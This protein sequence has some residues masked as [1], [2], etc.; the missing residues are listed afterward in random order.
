MFDADMPFGKTFRGLYPATA[1][2][3]SEP[4]LK[5]SAASKTNPLQFLCLTE[6]SGLG[7]G[8]LWETV[9]ALPG[10]SWTLN[11]GESP[12]D[13]EESRLW[14]ILQDEPPLKY[15]LSAKA[16]QGILNR[17]AKRG[18]ELPEMLKTA[19]T[20]VVRRDHGRIADTE[21]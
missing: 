1:A 16:C 17:A 15:C 19:L 11:T 9:S 20:D 6:G 21:A 13:A 4:C 14:Q 3:I 5:N 10:E 12:K 7:T 18:K 2:K 8:A